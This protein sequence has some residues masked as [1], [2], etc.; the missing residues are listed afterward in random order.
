MDRNEL[1]SLLAAVAAGDAAVDDAVRRIAALPATGFSDLG[2]ARVDH[3]RGVRTGDPE[4]VYGAGKT[5]EQVVAIVRSL[6]AHG[7]RPA[8]V[9]RAS[10]ETVAAVSGEWP[11]AQDESMARSAVT[12]SNAEP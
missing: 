4:V 2:F 6:A 12:P 3:H 1:R 5:P 7:D 11:D 10:D 9:T 8:L